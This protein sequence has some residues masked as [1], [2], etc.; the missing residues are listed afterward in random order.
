[1]EHIEV[2]PVD[3]Q[4]PCCFL[5]QTIRSLVIYDSFIR[6]EKSKGGCGHGFELDELPALYVWSCKR[7]HISDEKTRE[8]LG[9]KKS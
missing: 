9:A 5:C 3:I 2:N 1:M 6:C 8:E 4:I 7:G